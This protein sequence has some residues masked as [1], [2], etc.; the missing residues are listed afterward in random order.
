MT[1]LR[2]TLEKLVPELETREFKEWQQ[3]QRMAKET[4]VLRRRWIATYN[5]LGKM[6]REMNK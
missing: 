6:K 4:E 1:T 5:E 3:Y 2:T